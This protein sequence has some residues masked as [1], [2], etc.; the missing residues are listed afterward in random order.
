[1]DWKQEY[2]RKLVSIEEAARKIVSGDR[3]WCGPGPAAP[4]PLVEALGDRGLELEG[5]LL[6]SALALHPFKIFKSP[7][8]IGHINYHTIFYGG[9]ERAFFPVGNMNVNSVHFSKVA[10]T[11][12]NHYRINVLMTDVSLPDD[13]GYMYYGPLGVAAN[14]KVAE[15]AE[16]IIVQ[17]NKFQ[18]RVN[19]IEHRIH[20]KDVTWICEGDHPLPPLPQDIPSDVDTKIA[21]FLVNEIPDGSA[22]QLGLGGLSNAIGYQL[23]NKKNLSV[24]T[25][26]FV[27]S[28][29]DLVKK[30]V[31]TGRMV[32]G[33]GLG[34]NELYDFV[35]EGKVELQ[36]LRITNDPRVIA[37]V[38][39]IM[40]INVTLMLDLTGQACS[41]SIGFYQYS[42][43]GGQADFVRGAAWAKGG[44]SFLC[45]PSTVKT[46]DGQVRSTINAV[47]PPGA[48]VTT[49]RSDTMYVVTDYG[50]VNL[51]VRR[52]P[53]GSG[54]HLHRPS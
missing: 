6:V 5:V 10:E 12:E 20:V 19:G 48:V 33:F 50:I 16:K 42:A 36:P 45:L 4:I 44:K 21:S 22:I 13:E 53:T 25:E 51:F 24:H 7:D 46:K 31:I 52:S 38:D 15:K 8:F 1:M 28:M 37:K 29:F 9:Y 26:M 43:T 18:P 35:G 17:V 14:G 47:L 41:E 11:L 3:I 27:D 39:N 23:V 49:P 2:Q 34:S 30:G 40:S 32:A 54:A